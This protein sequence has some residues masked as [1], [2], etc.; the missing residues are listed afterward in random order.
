MKIAWDCFLIKEKIR[1]IFIHQMH[2]RRCI[3]NNKKLVLHA[4]KS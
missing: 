3:E 1:K 2:M 4:C